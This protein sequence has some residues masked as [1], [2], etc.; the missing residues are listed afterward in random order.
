MDLFIVDGI[1][2]NN[3]VY[4]VEVAQLVKQIYLPITVMELQKL[5]KKTLKVSTY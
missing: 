3:N 5:I 2:I 1:P 4:G